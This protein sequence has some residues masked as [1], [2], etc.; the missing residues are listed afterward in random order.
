[1][2]ITPSIYNIYICTHTYTHIYFSGVYADAPDKLVNGIP[3]NIELY[4]YAISIRTY[5][6]HMCGGSIISP[7]HIITAAHCVYPLLH[8]ASLRQSITVVS[9]TSTLS[10][11]GSI[12]KVANM[13]AHERYSPYGYGHDIGIIKV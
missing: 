5:N 3:T 11:G 6:H 8:D 7:Q 12:H 4:P 2:K 9:G 13:Y 10:S 1:L